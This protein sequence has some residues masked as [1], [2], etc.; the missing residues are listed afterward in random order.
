M[1]R[2][3]FLIY[4]LR[5]GDVTSEMILLNATDSNLEGNDFQN[6]LEETRRKKPSFLNEVLSAFS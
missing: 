4:F 6:V 2:Y 1:I 5:L 3:I